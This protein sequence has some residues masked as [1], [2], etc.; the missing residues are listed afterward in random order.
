M[1]SSADLPC[2]S[3]FKAAKADLGAAGPGDVCDHVVEQSQI[4]R[5]GFAPEEIHNP[6]NLD[7]YLAESTSSMANYY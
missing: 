1:A 7:P 2:Y 4:A 3:S 5:S 6:F